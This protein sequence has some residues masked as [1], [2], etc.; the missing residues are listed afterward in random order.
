MKEGIRINSWPHGNKKIQGTVRERKR[1]GRGLGLG[2]TGKKNDIREAVVW[3]FLLERSNELGA[4]LMLNV[5][6]LVIVTFL[7]AGISA[8]G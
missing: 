6:L 2:R 4:D 8:D 5:I 7:H 1:S 3:E